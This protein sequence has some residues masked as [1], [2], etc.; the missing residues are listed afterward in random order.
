MRKKK[1]GTATHFRVEIEEQ[2]FPM[3]FSVLDA[4]HQQIAPLPA[5]RAP[6]PADARDDSTPE[7]HVS[8][9]IRQSFARIV[10]SSRRPHPHNK[11]ARAGNRVGS[12][13]RAPV[14][15]SIARV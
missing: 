10:F 4:Y 1:N 2:Y 6:A 3:L 8:S 5:P 7:T 9:R 13:A 12:A 11:G 15:E 14:Q